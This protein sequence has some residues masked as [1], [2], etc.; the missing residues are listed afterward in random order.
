MTT[1]DLTCGTWFTLKNGSQVLVRMLREA[2]AESL[3]DFFTKGLS[4]TSRDLFFAYGMDPLI[5]EWVREEPNSDR[6]FRLIALSGD[7]IVAY[8][9]WRVQLTNPGLPLL[10]IAVADQYQGIGL[11]TLLMDLLIEEAKARKMKGIEL[12]VF[13][14][15]ARA[16]GLYKKLGFQV[17]GQTYDGRQWIMEKRFAPIGRRRRS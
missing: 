7:T 17:V 3:A 12:H 13:K 1:T 4:P 6:V 15:N 11:G 5:V 9:Y 2:D 14:H 8:A 10:S 16:L